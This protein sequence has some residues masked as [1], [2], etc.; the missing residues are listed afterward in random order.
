MSHCSTSLGMHSQQ[1]DT[2]DLF[3]NALD[4]HFV[5]SFSADACYSM[6]DR[7][8]QTFSMLEPQTSTTQSPNRECDTLKPECQ[9][10]PIVANDGG[11]LLTNS[12][13][14]GG[15]DENSTDIDF[16]IEWAGYTLPGAEQIRAEGGIRNA[17]YGTSL[18]GAHTTT[19]GGGSTG[20]D[21][22]QQGM[23][24]ARGTKR[25]TEAEAPSTKEK[26][27]VKA[28]WRKYGQKTI[29]GKED[30]EMQMTRCY[31]RCNYPGCQVKKQVETS[32][33]NAAPSITIRGIHNH[34]V[35]SHPQDKK[36]AKKRPRKGSRNSQ[37]VVQQ[38]TDQEVAQQTLNQSFPVSAL[39]C[40][41]QA[42]A[43]AVNNIFDTISEQSFDD[44]IS[45]DSFDF[46]ILDSQDSCGAS[47]PVSTST[48]LNQPFSCDFGA[49][50]FAPSGSTDALDPYF[51]PTAF[52][53]Q[54]AGIPQLRC[55]DRGQSAEPRMTCLSLSPFDLIEIDIMHTASDGS[56]PKRKRNVSYHNLHAYGVA[57]PDEPAA[58]PAPTSRQLDMRTTSSQLSYKLEEVA[59]DMDTYVCN[60]CKR[61]KLSA[62]N[63]QDGRVRI[64]CECGGKHRDGT[65]RMHAQWSA[66]AGDHREIY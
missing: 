40:S 14:F 61:H 45:V 7:M 55:E 24:A 60:Y 36:V 3:A 1:R 66:V 6:D 50:S 62:S 4:S 29:K 20:M 65:S 32:A 9:L 54:P 25:K 22:T 21:G 34:P 52:A 33:P 42:I 11:F 2:D 64:R 51:L 37:V 43:D 26:A 16:D 28:V 38:A 13:S 10:A 23:A 19:R 44:A 31:F 49:T 63:G 56:L 17:P 48:P 39:T 58:R 12:T 46:D 18:A 57:E 53:R 41:Q 5:D 8:D 59:E 15:G 27:K 30:T 35:E 47:N